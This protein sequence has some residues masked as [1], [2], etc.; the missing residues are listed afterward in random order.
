MKQK[1]HNAHMMIPR[2]LWEKARK[3]AEKERTNVTALVC[4]G[5]ELLIESRKEKRSGR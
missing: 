1:V 3:L 2:M 5:L 4:E